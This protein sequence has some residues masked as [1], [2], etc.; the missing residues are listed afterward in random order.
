MIT[1]FLDINIIL[2]SNPNAAKERVKDSLGET[3]RETL[4]FR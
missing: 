3:E 2:G 1:F 4:K